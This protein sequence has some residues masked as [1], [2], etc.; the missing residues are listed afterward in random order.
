MRDFHS[1]A[2]PRIGLDR[3]VSA[4]ASKGYLKWSDLTSDEEQAKTAI[5][6]IPD[7]QDGERNRAL[8]AYKLAMAPPQQAPVPPVPELP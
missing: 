3:Y 2:L 8:A 1:E 5:W 6:S 7:M 4:F